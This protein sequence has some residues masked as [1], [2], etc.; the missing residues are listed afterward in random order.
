MFTPGKMEEDMKVSTVTTKNT[1]TESTHGQI[2]ASIK[3]CG[4]VESSMDLVSIP[5]LV[6][7]LSV[8][9]GKM[10]SALN[11]L[12]TIKLLLFSMAN[13]NFQGISQSSQRVPRMS[14]PIMMEAEKSM[15]LA[16]EG[17]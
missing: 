7:N 2:N 10:A 8:A 1:V 16:L 6:K 3:V 14:S 4:S 9:S 15:A 13:M 17:H 5:S 12:I 11:G